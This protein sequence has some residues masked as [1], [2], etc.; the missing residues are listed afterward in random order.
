MLYTAKTVANEFLRVPVRRGEGH[1]GVAEGATGPGGDRRQVHRRRTRR[2]ASR[3]RRASCG[4]DGSSGRGSSG[5]V[6]VLEQQ[7]EPA[8]HGVFGLNGRRKGLILEGIGQTL[9]QGLSCSVSG[10]RYN[11]IETV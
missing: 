11:K 10:I 5:V 7:G 8:L 9:A 2:T 1:T 4:C 3:R 6:E